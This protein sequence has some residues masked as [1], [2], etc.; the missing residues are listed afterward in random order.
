MILISD[1]LTLTILFTKLKTQ[2]IYNYIYIY[3]LYLDWGTLWGDVLKSI[4]KLTQNLLAGTL[5]GSLSKIAVHRVNVVKMTTQLTLP[6]ETTAMVLVPK[7][8]RQSL[9]KQHVTLR[10]KVLPHER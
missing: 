7:R 10:T 3:I 2:N 8:L 6:L 1:Y 9:F 5:G 4:D